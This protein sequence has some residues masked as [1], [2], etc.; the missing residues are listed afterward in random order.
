ML[1]SKKK[2]LTIDTVIGAGT[3]IDGDLTFAGGL[4]LD[5]RVRGNVQADEGTSSML[6]ISEKGAVEGEVR[7]GHLIVNGTVSGP[8]R[9]GDLLEL[10]AQA[11]IYGEVYY[12][13][14]EMQQGAVVEGRLVP[15]VQ[16]DVK[17]L[18]HVVVDELDDTPQDIEDS[19]R[20][21]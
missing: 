19:A 2:A 13:A 16:A 10:Q 4:R 17:A 21:A 8:V 9:A 6:V 20:P 3:T 14:L 15:L 1:F 11:R 12:A 7:V 18:P 5:G